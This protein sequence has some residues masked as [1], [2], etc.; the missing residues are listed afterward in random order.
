MHPGPRGMEMRLERDQLGVLLEHLEGVHLLVRPPRRHVDVVAVAEPHPRPVAVLRLVALRVEDEPE[1]ELPG[2]LLDGRSN[3]D[4][5]PGDGGPS[6]LAAGCRTSRGRC[7]RCA[8]PRESASGCGCPR[9]RRCPRRSGPRWSRSCGGI[10]SARRPWTHHDLIASSPLRK[11]DSARFPTP[12][13]RGRGPAGLDRRRIPRPAGPGATRI[14]RGH[15][16]GL[17]VTVTSS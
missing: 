12:G 17:T 11:Q 8:R 15:R 3:A 2:G 13:S 1:L 5:W 4:G 7:P 9:P 6:R 16:Y 10:G 14:P